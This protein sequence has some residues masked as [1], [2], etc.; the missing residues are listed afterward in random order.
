MT[1]PLT[2]QLY[3]QVIVSVQA[4]SHEPLGTVDCLLAMAQS[5][6][7]GGAIAL[8]LANPDTIAPIKSALPTIP[9]IGITKPKTPLP[10]PE[11]R[12][13]ITPALSDAN[14]VARAGADIIAMDATLRPRQ[15]PLQQVV[16]TLKQQFPDKLL[17][18]DIATLED[19]LSAA[20][21]GFDWIGTTLSGYTTET[22]P[23]GKS[24]APDFELL[25]AIVSRISIPVILEGRVWTPEHVT[26]AFQR[27]AH[28]VVIG[29]AITRPQL[30][31]RR[32]IQAIPSL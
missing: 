23:K 14:A 2:Q 5:A 26:E 28:A 1:H 29:S 21:T 31:T 25:S 18:A 24:E 8:R 12:V 9:V 32:F 4:E 11:S 3:R 10:D 6:V 19:A 16:Q 22:L 27:G 17:M 15:E 13:Y 20:E 30:I 7:N